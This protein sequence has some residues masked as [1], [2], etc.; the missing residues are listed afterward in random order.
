MSKIKINLPKPSK[1]TNDQ[2]LKIAKTAAYLA[3]SSLISGLIALVQNNPE[4]FGAY[5][6]VVNVV[7]VALK[8]VFTAP[9]EQ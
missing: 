2:L 1:V 5:L 7:L 9:E 4:Q 8:Q 6:A 3:V